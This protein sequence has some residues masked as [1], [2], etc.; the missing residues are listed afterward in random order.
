MPTRQL[1]LTYKNETFS[2]KIIRSLLLKSENNSNVLN[3]G[4]KTH[5]HFCKGPCAIAETTRDSMQWVEK[6]NLPA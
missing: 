6:E 3:P 1:T 2:R 4:Q 5:M